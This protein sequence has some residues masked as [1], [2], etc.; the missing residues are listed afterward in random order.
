LQVR[1]RVAA[2]RGRLVRLG[3]R[4]L[5]VD[6]VVDQQPPDLLV[7]NMADELFDVDPAVAESSALAV[8]LGDLGLDGDDALEPWLEVI[9]RLEIYRPQ[10]ES[11]AVAHEVTLI[12][13]DGTGPELSDATRR[14]LEATGVELEWDVQDAGADVMEQYGGNPLPEHVLDSITRTGVALKGPITTP[15]G[16]RKSVGREREESWG[17][18]VAA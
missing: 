1:R 15:V 16:D 12:P 8:R 18:G 14:V 4:H 10:L 3:V 17:G 5:R 6:V 9:H 7:G 2:Q 11:R 13:G